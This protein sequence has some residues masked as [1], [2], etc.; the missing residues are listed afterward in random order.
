MSSR[1]TVVLVVSCVLCAMCSLHAA[2]QKKKSYEI[3]V[4]EKTVGRVLHGTCEALGDR[5]QIRGYFPVFV[6]FNCQSTYH[7][8]RPGP[9][10]ASRVHAGLLLA[11][12]PRVR[13]WTRGR[14]SKNCQCTRT[15]HLVHSNKYARYLVERKEG[16]YEV[17]NYTCG[18]TDT[19]VHY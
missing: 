4:H 1:C 7:G 9:T 19:P 6:T 12:Q 13:E 15:I 5:K 3:D 2:L 18:T 17:Y 14:K 11:Q 10:L 8:P 16:L